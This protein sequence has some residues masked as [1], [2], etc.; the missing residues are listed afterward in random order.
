MKLTYQ[1]IKC[2]IKKFNPTQSYSD[3]FKT[4][5]TEINN[6]IEELDD[7][8]CDGDWKGNHGFATELRNKMTHRNSPNVAV[9]SDYD[10]N[11]KNHPV[12]LIKR[13]L[14]DYVVVSKCIEEILDMIEEE[15]IE[16]FAEE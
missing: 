9:L 4:K 13:I 15:F 6:Y 16:C 14:E 12:F 8:E 7:I 5:A 1:K 3:N 11:L 2:S 10:M